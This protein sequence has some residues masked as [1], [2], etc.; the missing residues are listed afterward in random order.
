VSAAAFTL[1]P[2]RAADEETAIELWRRT[3]Q[4]AYPHLDFTARLDWWRE[5][6]R[7]ELVPATTVILAES[8]D[9][10]VGFVT[11]DTKTLYLDQIVVAPEAWGS[12]VAVALIDAA[13]R[14]SP[15]RLDLLVNQD[16]ARAIRFY[17]KH[18]F[19][20]AGIDTNPRSGAPLYRMSWRRG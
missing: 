11:V 17:E 16:N 8:G 12:N 10:V 9:E 7:N 19:A 20:V 14:M 18:G 2:Y 5:R 6:W 3:W 1:R 4:V 13:K 15:T